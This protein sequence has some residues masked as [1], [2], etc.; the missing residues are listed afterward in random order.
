MPIPGA[1]PLQP[2][3]A[4]P[5]PAKT[6]SALGITG[7]VIVTL[8]AI[9][10][11]VSAW[12]T[13][14]LLGGFML[15]YGTTSIKYELLTAAEQAQASAVIMPGV[16]ASVVGVAGFVLSIVAV[17]KKNGRPW[18]IAGIILGIL[19]PLA[20]FGLTMLGVFGVVGEFMY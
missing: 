10:G 13:G 7:G 5:A 8:C 11:C 3:Y 2:Y 4:E 6:S 16:L 19:A 20:M 15:I 12:M 1:P 17:V 9:V 14:A 18:G